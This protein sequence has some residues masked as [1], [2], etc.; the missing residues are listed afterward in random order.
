M[1]HFRDHASYSSAVLRGTAPL[2]AAA[3]PGH[4]GGSAVAYGVAATVAAA[5][6]AWLGLQGRRLIE[7]VPRAL[8]RRPGAVLAAMRAAHSGHVGDYVAWWTFGV[9]VI[10]GLMLWAVT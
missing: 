9:T 10:G 2:H 6:L 7:R 1:A 3:A 4:V 8:V 5:A